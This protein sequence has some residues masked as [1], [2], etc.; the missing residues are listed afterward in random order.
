MRITK[1]Q[2]NE[3]VRRTLRE[4]TDER[5]NFGADAGGRYDDEP[6]YDALDRERPDVIESSMSR[7]DEIAAQDQFQADTAEDALDYEFEQ[8]NLHGT[9]YVYTAWLNT[10]ADP[11][12]MYVWDQTAGAWSIDPEGHDTPDEPREDFGADI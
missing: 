10:G 11:V 8:S 2:I 3:I 9:G 1:K 5:E 6:D 12:P 4:W 7:N